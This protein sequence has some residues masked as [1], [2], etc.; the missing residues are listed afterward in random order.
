M[1]MRT[2]LSSVSKSAAASVLA[3][4]VLPTPVGPRKMN[5]PIGRRGALIPDRARMIASDT[6][7][8]PSSWPTRPSCSTSSSPRNFSRPPSFRR[9]IAMSGLLLALLNLLPQGLHLAQ[10]L[11]LRVPLGVRCVG[12]GPQ[13]GQLFAKLLQSLTARG[14]LLLG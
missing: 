9:V 10:C 13:I 6:N 14:V 2:M 3:S 8:T 5:D 7:W 4:S 1:S 12:L 11:P